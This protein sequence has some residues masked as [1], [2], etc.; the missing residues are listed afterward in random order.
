MAT[1]ARVALIAALAAVR[2]ARLAVDVTELPA[3]L[4]LSVAFDPLC[5]LLFLVSFAAASSLCGVG[6]GRLAA[7]VA[8][9]L[10]L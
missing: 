4:T 7:L 5:L 6:P 8:F 2:V 10:L 3:Q 1:S 9:D